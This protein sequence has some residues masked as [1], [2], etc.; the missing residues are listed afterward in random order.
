MQLTYEDKI[1]KIEVDDDTV[2]ITQGGFQV[3][4]DTTG[5]EV[6]QAKLQVTVDITGK[7]TV[8][9]LSGG[10][11]VEIVAIGNGLDITATNGQTMSGPD[12][13]KSSNVKM[14]VYP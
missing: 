12:P 11:A 2:E 6:T 1:T 14:H 9:N 7:V 10:I 13:L 4:I 3:A 8:Q 5:V